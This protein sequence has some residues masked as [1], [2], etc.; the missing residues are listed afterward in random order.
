M[1]IDINQ[2][3]ISIGDKYQVFIDGALR[4]RASRILFR[5][6]AT[7]KLFDQDSDI[8]RLTIHRRLSFFKP[9]YD[10]IL[11]DENVLPFYTISFWKLHYQ[12]KA[13]NDTY[14]IYGHRGRKYSIFKN[15]RQTG[16][17]DKK[18][19]TWFAGDNYTITADNNANTALLIA[20]CL[21]ID[22]YRSDDH[23]GGALKYDFGNIGFSTRPFD[24]SWRPTA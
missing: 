7:V 23:E 14:D 22:N 17:W 12:C 13:G 8:A 2:Q 20:F 5:W 21:V 16:W 6:L 11:R 9:K 24:S 19:V 10:I 15:N 3:K 18:A 1:E 4:F